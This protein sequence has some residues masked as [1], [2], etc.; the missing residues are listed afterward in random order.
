MQL[1]KDA[2]ENTTPHL[3]IVDDDLDLCEVLTRYMEAEDFRFVGTYRIEG[4]KQES[5]GRRN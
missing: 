3:L 5:K 4:S 1:P 2:S